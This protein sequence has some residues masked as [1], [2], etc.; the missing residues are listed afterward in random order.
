MKDTIILYHNCIVNIQETLI[1]ENKDQSVYLSK[2]K[3]QN[4]ILYN[5]PLEWPILL[6]STVII[7]ETYLV[8]YL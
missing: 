5:A 3:T 8:I 4:V 1:S 6:P 2:I 7:M